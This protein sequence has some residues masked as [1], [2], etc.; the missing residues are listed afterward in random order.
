M[1]TKFIAAALTALTLTAGMTA[2]TGEAQAR[3]RHGAL[4]VGIAAGLVGAAIIA[5][6]ATPTYVVEPRHRRCRWERQFNAYGEYMGR[7]KVCYY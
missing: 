3:H 4:G 7:V 5:N 1:K 6:S 2:L